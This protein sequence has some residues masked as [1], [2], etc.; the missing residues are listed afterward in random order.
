MSRLVRLYVGRMLIEHD[1]LGLEES[2]MTQE[3][4]EV[5]IKRISDMGKKIQGEFLICPLD[6]SLILEIVRNDK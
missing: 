5:F 2:M 6:I 1:Y 4:Q 3:D